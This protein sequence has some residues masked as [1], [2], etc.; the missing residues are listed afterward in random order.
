MNKVLESLYEQWCDTHKDT[1]EYDRAYKALCENKNI[2]P[3]QANYNADVLG[4]CVDAESKQA[5]NAG[6]QTAVQL[7]TSNSL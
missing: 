2:T 6:F 7:L 1:P 3:K 5:F 4:V